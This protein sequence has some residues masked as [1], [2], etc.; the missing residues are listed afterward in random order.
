MNN[1]TLAQFDYHLPDT[2]I[3]QTPSVHRDTSKLLH[4]CK[5]KNKISDH[6]FKS[7]VDL[8]PKNACIV[9]NN[10]K[11]I[12]S[13]IIA[14]R[15][16]GAKIECFFLEK[17]SKNNWKVLIKNSKRIKNN[18][19]L[20]VNENHQIT[21]IKK[22]EKEAYV[23]I[24]GPL[25]DFEFLEAFGEPP[26]PP[27]IKSKR[28]KDHSNRYQSVFASEP[29]AVAAPT[30]SLHFTKEVFAQLDQKEI[31]IIYITLHIGLGTFNPIIS[32]NII[33]HK[34]HKESYKICKKSAQKLN[35]AKKNRKPIIAIGT[36]SARCLESNFHNHAFHEENSTTDLYIYP[37]Y[38]FK[39]INGMLTNF[40][41]PK[42]SLLILV[43]SLIGIKTTKQIYNH[44]ISKKYKFF[45]YGDAMLIT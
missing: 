7:F 25:S 30:A 28:P 39:A 13:R 9:L 26:L 3:A 12:K 18:E 2:L 37:G 44:A 32:N 23:E 8:L 4:F 43:C 19:V 35:E 33:E 17:C 27:Y 38:R 24:S 36:T 21:I 15:L 41:L 29:G 14:K 10:T 22:L 11:V 31:E 20:N 5:R 16:T 1:L 45:S 6:T 40:H 42:S 34:M